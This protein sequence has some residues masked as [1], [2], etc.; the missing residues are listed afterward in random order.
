MKTYKVLASH[1]TYVYAFVEAENKDEAY[2]IALNMDGGEFK[3][4][5][6][7]DWNIDNVT[8]VTE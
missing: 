3:T 7:G 6:E 5:H 1:T 4:T 8:E 2:Q